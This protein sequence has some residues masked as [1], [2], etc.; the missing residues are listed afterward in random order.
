MKKYKFLK[1]LFKR[2]LTANVMLE[3]LVVFAI[4]LFVC[5]KIGPKLI[6]HICGVET[7]MFTLLDADV[8]KLAELISN[9]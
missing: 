5:V 4:T 7:Q 6:A 2:K 9:K 1:N 8:K 3:Y